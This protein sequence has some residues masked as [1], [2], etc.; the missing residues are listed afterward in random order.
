M[1]DR[2]KKETC[3]LHGGET[4]TLIWEYIADARR[5][6]KAVEGWKNS[7][8]GSSGG[9]RVPRIS[10]QIW[11]GYSALNS[12]LPLSSTG[13]RF[14]P[15]LVNMSHLHI[16]GTF[17]PGHFILQPIRI[18]VRWLHARPYTKKYFM[19]EYNFRSY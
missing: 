8:T 19:V 14:S 16:F 7:S 9:S 15:F 2:R 18:L 11:S 3:Q 10:K 17:D 6:H 13:C 4:R 5:D 12:C 1:Y